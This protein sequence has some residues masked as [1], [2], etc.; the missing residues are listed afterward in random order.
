MRANP[1]PPSATSHVSAGLGL[2]C[3]VAAVLLLCG[4]E[5]PLFSQSLIVLL[6]VAVPVA[7]Y[8]SLVLKVHRRESSG[9]DF[10]NPPKEGADIRRI[11]VKLHGLFATWAVIAGLYWLLPFYHE[12]GYIA[13][14]STLKAMLPFM[15]LFAIPYFALMDRYMTD[16]KDG[17]W[18]A[19]ML[20]LGRWRGLDREKL[21]E[22]AL[23]WTVKA[24]FLAFMCSILPALVQRITGTGWA[25]IGEGI[26]PAIL[27]IVFFLFLLDVVFGTVGYICAFRPLD[28]HIR[29]SNPFVAGW[30][31][32][33]SCYPP[34]A[35]MVVG[36]VIAYNDGN[37]WHDW[38]ADQPALLMLWGAIMI[39]L[40]A[41][42]A[43]ATIV[44][45][46]RF[47]NLTNRGIIT[48]G[49]YRFTKHPAYLTKNVYWWF[50]AMPFLA[51]GGI[52]EAVRNCVFLGIVNL[53]YL[54]RAKTEERHLAA[55]PAYEAYALWM[56]ENGLFRRL[57]RAL[58][59]L[60]F[61]PRAKTAETVPAAAAE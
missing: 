39:V 48:H 51:E 44:F 47:S 42:Y 9:L 12:G 59:A 2:A 5:M 33:L 10:A 57:G 7:L 21:R 41:V 56:E 38:L 29:S 24:F 20:F 40:T 35:L 23:G 13:Y 15:V 28:S 55:D 61:K 43:W 8:D 34:F 36:G 49:P 17:Y 58:P 31:A 52:E 60:R 11:C 32:A 3:L 22:H 1:P 19:G 18:H 16:S 26:V 53:I 6:A 27:W 54:W 46:I 45:G 14:L 30:L 25:E 50:A 4:S 37:Y